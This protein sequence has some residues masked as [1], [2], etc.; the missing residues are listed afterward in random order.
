MHGT[1]VGLLGVPKFDD[2]R[3]DC[4]QKSHLCEWRLM[5]KQVPSQTSLHPGWISC[6]CTLI[7]SLDCP[8][9]HLLNICLRAPQR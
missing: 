7:S 9:G 5:R 2:C 4:I 1:C 6:M 3:H 8:G